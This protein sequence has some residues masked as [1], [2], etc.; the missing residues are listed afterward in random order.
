M[1][2]FK[3]YLIESSLNDDDFYLVNTKTKKIVRHLGGPNWWGK[4]APNEVKKGADE[5]VLTGLQT[6]IRGFTTLK[7]EA[8]NE[9]PKYHDLQ[10]QTAIQALNKYAKDALWMLHDDT[11]LYRGDP[12]RIAEKTGFAIV[13]TSG[14][15]RKSQNTSNFYTVILD[16]HPDRQQFPK[17]SR[18]FICTTIR[19]SATGYAHGSPNIIIPFDGVPIGAV[20]QRDMWSTYLEMFGRSLSIEDFNDYYKSFRIAPTMQS[21]EAAAKSMK[22]PTSKLSKNFIDTFGEQQYKKVKDDFMKVIFDAYSA[23]KTGHTLHTT[24]NL[25]GVEGEVWVG[26]KVIVINQNMWFKL[27]DAYITSLHEK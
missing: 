13:N 14:T 6:K 24:A 4:S 8:V 17:R 23:K 11:P 20:N 5:E 2:T 7:E 27:R 18:S 12:D 19:S 3:Q 10:V 21:F 1:I 9:K 16:N 26:G 25:K 22:D 15:E